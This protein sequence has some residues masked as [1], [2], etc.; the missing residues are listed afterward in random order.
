MQVTLS[1]VKRV[2]DAGCAYKVL[3]DGEKVGKIRAGKVLAFDVAPGPHQ[4]QCSVDRATSPE[5]PF[6][7]GDAD[8]V[9]ECEAGEG[10]L[11]AKFDARY[12]RGTY[13]QLRQLT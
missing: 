9:F 4:L 3:L 13:L 6:V 1:R 11:S 7:A 5:V 10:R 12:N 2:R 8:L